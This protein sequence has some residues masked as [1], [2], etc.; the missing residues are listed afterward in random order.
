MR[1]LLVD[2][3]PAFLDVAADVVGATPGL[4]SI[5]AVSSPDEA[6]ALVASQQP[7]LAV[8]DVNMPQ[9]AGTELTRRIKALCPATAVALI[10]AYEPGQLPPD[11]HSCGADAILEKRDFLPQRLRAI[12]AD[13]DRPR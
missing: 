11:A 9:M 13:L 5:G 12:A 7:E 4:T 3:S 2:D 10:S 8:V 6:L 1:I